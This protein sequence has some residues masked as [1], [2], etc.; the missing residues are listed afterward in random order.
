M[1]YVVGG[2][3]IWGYVSPPPVIPKQPHK[4]TWAE[5]LGTISASRGFLFCFMEEH[6][7][8]CHRLNSGCVFSL[9]PFPSSMPL[10][11]P[12]AFCC[13]CCCVS[14][15]K[16]KKK[17]AFGRAESR[18]AGSPFVGQVCGEPA[19]VSSPQQPACSNLLNMKG[20]N[21]KK[22]AIHPLL[23]HPGVQKKV[24]RLQAFLVIP[25]PSPRQQ[26]QG[27][28]S[29]AVRER[30]GGRGPLPGS[31]LPSLFPLLASP[32]LGPPMACR[33][34]MSCSGLPAPQPSSWSPALRG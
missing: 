28:G 29:P 5:V 17:G 21:R 19:S 27:A 18:L 13:C 7:S 26:S 9:S 33:K 32:L 30:E 8:H 6:P 2:S 22:K 14:H 20:P 23:L 15:S 12:P 11:V 10:T 1:L 16:K 3:R 24:T 34:P 25:Q 4:A 31:D